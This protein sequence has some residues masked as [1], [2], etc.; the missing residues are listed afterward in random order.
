MIYESALEICDDGARGS[1]GI[2]NVVPGLQSMII[3]QTHKTVILRLFSLRNYH[4]S[5][6]VGKYRDKKTNL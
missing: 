5:I 4:L 1:K 2:A 3:F 6:R